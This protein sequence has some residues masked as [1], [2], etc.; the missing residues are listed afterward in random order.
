[1][2]YM[3]ER[4]VEAFREDAYLRA[5]EAEVIEVND[6]G[7]IVLDKTVFYATGGGQPGDVGSIDIEND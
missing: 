4:T 6:R 7:G 1:M 3:T 5:C 2:R